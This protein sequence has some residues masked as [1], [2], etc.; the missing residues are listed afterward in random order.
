MVE[1]G[2]RPNNFIRDCKNVK[3]RPEWLDEPQS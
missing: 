1:L 2:V 3:K